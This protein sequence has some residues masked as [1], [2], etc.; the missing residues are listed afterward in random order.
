MRR[1]GLR[2]AGGEGRVGITIKESQLLL[3]RRT[4]GAALPGVA[5]SP[6]EAREEDVPREMKPS[7]VKGPFLRPFE[8]F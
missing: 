5:G 3:R 4:G 8:R 1:A 7:T 2:S 6:W